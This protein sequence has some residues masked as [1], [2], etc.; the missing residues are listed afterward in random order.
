[1]I[2]VIIKWFAQVFYDFRMYFSEL[3]KGK[4]TSKVLAL[5]IIKTIQ[6]MRYLLYDYIRLKKTV[7]MRQ[8]RLDC[9]MKQFFYKPDKLV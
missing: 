4:N 5:V 7:S 3:C 1:M 6:S 9:R 2:H 8:F